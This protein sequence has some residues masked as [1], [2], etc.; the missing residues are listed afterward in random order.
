M[1]AVQILAFKLARASLWPLYLLLLA[2]AARVA[3][4]PRSLGILVSAVLTAAAIAVF[5][6]EML[7]LLTWPSDG[8][9]RLLESSCTGGASARTHGPI[10]GR[11]GRLFAASRLHLR[12]RADRPGRAP[13]HRPC[14]RPAARDRVRA[15]GLGL[16]RSLAHPQVACARV[17]GDP[18]RLDRRAALNGCTSDGLSLEQR[19]LANSPGAGLARASPQIRRLSPCWLPRLRSSFSTYVAI[20]SRPAGLPP[21]VGRLCSPSHWRWS[22]IAGSPARSA[23]MPGGGRGPAIPGRWR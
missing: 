8:S 22:A 2:Y 16:V 14:A 1:K 23:A 17:A 10:P 15:F 13:V 20:A 3:P 5:F 12:S 21:G 9:K 6:H 4:W 11:G 7:R 18:A 19:R